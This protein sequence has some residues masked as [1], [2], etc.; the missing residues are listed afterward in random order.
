MAL[1]S[2]LVPLG[3]PA[4]EFALPDVYGARYSLS[5]FNTAALVVVFACNHCPYVR[6]IEDELCTF[7][8]SNELSIVAI[9]PNDIARYPDDAPAKLAEQARRAGWRFPY[10]VDADQSVARAYGA[11]CTPDF[12]VYG[13]DRRLSYRGAF[14]A[15]TPGNKEP[16]TGSDLRHAVNLTIAGK[17]VPE[18]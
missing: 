11:V 13:P 7:V 15:S 16:V 12:F 14:D 9:C 6:H 1:T 5:V 17:P 18:P 8:P 2:S 4:P 10:L 3:T